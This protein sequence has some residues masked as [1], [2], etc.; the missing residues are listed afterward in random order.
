VFDFTSDPRWGPFSTSKSLASARLT[1]TL[2][3]KSSLVIQDIIRIQGLADI[4]TAQIQALPI[5]TTGTVELELLD[6]YSS[7]EI[8]NVL[9][10]DI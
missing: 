1:L 4:S 8:L 2:T 10:S 6:F 3:P 5:N 7:A 9:T